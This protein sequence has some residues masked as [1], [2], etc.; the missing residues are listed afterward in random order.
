MTSDVVADELKAWG[1]FDRDNPYPLFAA[2]QEL[3]PVHHV[4][5]VDGVDAWLV[6][7]HDEAREVL[8]DARISKDMHAALALDGQV[9]AEGLPGPEF[10]RHML[11]VD[12]PDHSRLRRLVS[13][14]FTPGAVESLR[15]RIQEIID[16]L[17]D[18]IAAHDPDTPTD[19]VARFAFPLPFTVICELLGIPPTERESLG[20]GLVAMLVATPSQGEYDKAKAA[21]DTVVALLY[22]VVRDKHEAPADDLISALIAARDGE[23]RLN[24]QELLSTV[25]QLIVAGHD[26]TTT[27]IGNAVV[28]LLDQPDQLA[29]LHGE[30]DCIPAAM[31]ELLRFDAPVPH[32]TFRYAAEPVEIGGRTIPTGAQVIVSLAAANRDPQRFAEPDRLDLQR[33]GARHVAFGHGIHHCL[34]A[35]LARL[36]GELAL[37]SLIRRFPALRLACP[38]DE[39]HWHHGDGL[40]LRGLS[41]LPVF[42]GRARSTNSVYGEP[43]ANVEH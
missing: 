37:R 43:H 12:P 1:A 5:L 11:A 21:S 41:S 31:E 26:T 22:R 27:F 8:K 28:A 34:G 36:E 20:Q 18:E 24:E 3:G 9:L 7:G 14:A 42:P 6:V 4:T 17:L 19:L 16:D 25:F 38:R 23:E 33:T 13:S 29:L 15:A 10:A 2:V 39:L 35:P 30:P 40:V 32:S